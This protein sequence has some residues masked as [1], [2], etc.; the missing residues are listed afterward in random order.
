MYWS[1]TRYE[2]VKRS[3]LRSPR[4]KRQDDKKKGW[5]MKWEKLSR[6][7]YIV[8][9]CTLTI[10]LRRLATVC[11]RSLAETRIWEQILSRTWSSH[12]IRRYRGK[13]EARPLHEWN[14]WNRNKQCFHIREKTKQ[15]AR[16]KQWLPEWIINELAIERLVSFGSRVYFSMVRWTS[17]YC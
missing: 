16:T 2:Y 1:V 12:R 17:T 10:L 3:F 11:F 15:V 9:T 14:N 13:T 6:R 4:W 8:S 5:K 7:M